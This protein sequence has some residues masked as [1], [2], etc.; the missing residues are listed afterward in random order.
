MTPS[1][2]LSP[3]ARHNHNKRLISQTI[4]SSPIIYFKHKHP[5]CDHRLMIYENDR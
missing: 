3:H 2:S 1:G 4:T 5:R